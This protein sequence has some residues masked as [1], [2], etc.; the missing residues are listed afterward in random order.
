M[1]RFTIVLTISELMESMLLPQVVSVEEALDRSERNLFLNQYSVMIPT[2]NRCHI[3]S[4]Y[5]AVKVILPKTNP[6]K[7]DFGTDYTGDQAVFLRTVH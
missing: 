4:G 3:A 1:K 7:Q 6:F 5:G 2:C